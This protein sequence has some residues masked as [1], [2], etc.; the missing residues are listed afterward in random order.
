LDNQL[1]DLSGGQCIE[2]AST[3]DTDLDSVVCTA[4]CPKILELDWIIFDVKN[5]K[6][7]TDY[8]KVINPGELL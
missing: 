2:I 5:S 1:A 4:S 7:L 3:I 8:T 6:V